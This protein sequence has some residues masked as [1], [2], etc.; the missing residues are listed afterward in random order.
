MEYLHCLDKVKL[1]ILKNKYR[2]G[3][4]CASIS[5]RIKFPFQKGLVCA[6]FLQNKNQKVPVKNKKK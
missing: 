5:E 6:K 4:G 3:F 2:T 1:E